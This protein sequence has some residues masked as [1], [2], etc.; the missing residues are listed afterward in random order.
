[1][2]RATY[3]K[4]CEL[5]MAQ[6]AISSRDVD[7]LLAW[8]E[9]K[10]DKGAEIYF[11]T[12]STADILVGEGLNRQEADRIKGKYLVVID[13]SIITCAHRCS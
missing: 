13:Q 7:A 10:H 12:S 2:S 4:H 3:T 5:R 11:G 6:R 1:M 9:F 8:G